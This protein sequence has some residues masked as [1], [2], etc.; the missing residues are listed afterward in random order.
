M[1]IEE[2]QQVL[3]RHFDE[4]QH[5]TGQKSLPIDARVAQIYD[6]IDQ[7]ELETQVE[8]F[9]LSTSAGPGDDT[10]N[11]T[12]SRTLLHFM[13]CSVATEV[14]SDSKESIERIQ[15]LMG[16]VAARRVA[17]ATTLLGDRLLPLSVVLLERVRSAACRCIGWLVKYLFEAES[18]DLQ[19]LE[20]LL[21]TS[22][23]ALVPR[24]TD[25]AQSVR[26]AAIEASRYFFLG[27]NKGG[28]EEDVDD[29]DIRQ[30]LQWSL[31][32]DPSV[33]NRVAALDSIPVTLQTMDVILARVRDVKSK[34]RVAAVTTLRNKLGD[35][36]QWEPEQCAEL[37]EAGLT[38]R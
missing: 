8:K 24:F 16:A 12:I 9:S 7:L 2:I 21:D 17:V 27:S 35:I 37:V 36:R 5:S 1:A 38:D 11:E 10:T 22:S 3:L 29:P 34:V 20:A 28:S 30:A 33:T 32:H 25:K 26:Q 6:E 15:E 4:H 19:E 23:Q 14:S 13:D 31:Q 18:M